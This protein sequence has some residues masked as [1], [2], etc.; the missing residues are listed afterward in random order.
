MCHSITLCQNCNKCL[1][2]CLKSTCRGKTSKLLASL[3]RSGR[4][5]HSGSNPERGLH[6]PVPDPPQT[7]KIPNCRELLCKSPQEQL[8]DGGIASA[9]RQKCCGNSTK[10]KISGFLQSAIPSAQTKQQMET[11]TRPKQPQSLP[12]GGEIQDGDTGNYQNLPTNGGMGNLDRFQRCLLPYPHTGTVQEISKI[13]CTGPVLPVQS[14][15]LRSIYSSPGVHCHSKGGETDGHPQGYTDPPVPRRLVGASHIP[16]GLSPAYPGPSKDV[17]RTGLAGELGKI[18][19][20]TQANLRF[21]RLPVRPQD[22]PGP[23]HTGPVAKPER[24]NTGNSVSTGLSGPAVHVLDWSANS[25]RKTSS[26]RSI[27]HE[28]YTMAPQKQ[29][30]DTGISGEDNPYP[31][32]STSS[33]TVVDEGRQC[34]H[35]PASTPREACYSDLHGCIKRRVG[36]SLERAHSKRNLVPTRKQAAHKLPRVKSSISSPKRVPRS[37]HRPDSLDGNRQHHSGVV[38]KQG[39]RHEVG[40]TMCLTV[41]NLDLVYQEASDSQS[42]THTGQIECYRRQAFP[43]RPNHSDRMVPPPRDIRGDMQQVALSSDR[44]LCHQLQQQTASICVPDARSS[45]HRCGCIQPALGRS[46]HI[47]LP[48]DSHIGQSGGEVAGHPMQETYSH[49]PRV[50]QH[51]LVLG[52]SV[53]VQSDSTMPAQTA[54]SL[55]T[56]LQ[57]DSPQESDY[58]TNL[59][60]HA[61]L[62]EPQQ[63]RSRVSLRQWQHELRLLKE[64]QPDQSMRQSGPFLQSGASVIR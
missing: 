22:R 5:P 53:H 12:Q 60:L 58:L 3:A 7:S 34:P 25:H 15:A 44:S 42:P 35:R 4:Q 39:R 8:P 40:P 20:G 36:S 45:G 13:P 26:P 10:P 14:T 31:H 62:L 27:T 46:G 2:C 28:A 17:Q 52:P 1:E 63:S 18:R 64:D 49:C 48:S 30:E 54:Q 38:H 57:S 37:L 24:Q 9:Y 16:P 55:N 33:S 23:T 51:A 6:P 56:T 29:L 21:R 43:V 41:E 32:I 47:R 61:W 19:A 50:A 59:N 11:H